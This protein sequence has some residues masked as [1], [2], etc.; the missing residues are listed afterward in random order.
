MFI[1]AFGF[2]V[3]YQVYQKRKNEREELQKAKESGSIAKMAEVL[4]KRSGTK[5]NSKTKVDLGEIENME[6]QLKGLSKS[7]EGMR[8]M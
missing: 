8:R 7:V 2:V 6:K 1:L 5:L 4:A 3:L